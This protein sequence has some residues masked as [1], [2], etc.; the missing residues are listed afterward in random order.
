MNARVRK[1]IGTLGILLFVG[2]YAWLVVAVGDHVPKV[3]WALLPY[4][5]IAGTAWGLPII[6]LIAWMNRG[7]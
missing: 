4:Y 6:P 2:L 7:R 1:A 3:W 5:V